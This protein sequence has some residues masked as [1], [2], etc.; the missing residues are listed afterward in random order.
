MCTCKQAAHPGQGAAA[1]QES[2][3]WGDGMSPE[4][5]AQAKAEGRK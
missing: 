1:E 5:A 2:H 3:F 4:Q